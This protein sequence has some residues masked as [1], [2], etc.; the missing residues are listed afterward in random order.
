M[1]K[2][3]EIGCD[4]LAREAIAEYPVQ[5]VARYIERLAQHAEVG[6][7]SA[8]A[9]PSHVGQPSR[10]LSQRTQEGNIPDARGHNSSPS[11]KAAFDFWLKKLSIARMGDDILR[12]MHW[13]PYPCPEAAC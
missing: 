7:L 6:S 5:G 1:H 12:Q 8:P 9:S 13:F 10:I 4:A 11:E 3:A 2:R